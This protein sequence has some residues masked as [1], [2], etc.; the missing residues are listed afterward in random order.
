MVKEITTQGQTGEE[1]LE[2][3]ADQAEEIQQSEEKKLEEQQPITA[4]RSVHKNDSLTSYRVRF[5]LTSKDI[6]LFIAYHSYSRW[7]GFL[8][9]VFAIGSLI[10]LPL[11]YFVWED[12]LTSLILAFVVFMYLVVAPLTMLSQAK[13]QSLN[14]PVFKHKMTYQIE[15][16]RVFVQQYTGD[17]DLMWTD[18]ERIGRFRQHYFFYVNANQAFILPL[19]SLKNEKK[20]FKLQQMIEERR[21]GFETKKTV[22]VE[23]G[24]E[25]VREVE[26]TE[27]TSR[28]EEKEIGINGKNGKNN[29]T[30]S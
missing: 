5:K 19:M 25:V 4:E 10:A 7:S 14:N 3:K 8:T 18:F 26:Q 20:R 1:G 11:T 15:E 22:K 12:G 30:I 9:G 16:E 17:V 27:E 28:S 2:K 29:D 24:Q 6:F 23:E 21:K 13:R